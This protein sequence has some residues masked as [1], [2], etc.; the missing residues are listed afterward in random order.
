M[1][2]PQI[3]ASMALALLSLPADAKLKVDVDS[4]ATF[5]FSAAKTWAW[6]P[7]IPSENELYQGRIVAGVEAALAAEG[8]TRVDADPD[9]WVVTEV[10]TRQEGK[11][12]GG[13]VSIGLSRRTKYGS[14]GVG[15]SG[16]QRHTKVTVGTL[17]IAILG[18][19]EGLVWRA[20]ASDTISNNSEKTSATIQK[21]IDQ[22]FKKYPPPTKK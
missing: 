3:I 1:K 14:I 8:M 19:D 16:G 13:N 18:P 4:D 5:D 2:K 12:S 15:T 9:I 10:A 17:V 21:A 6:K 22:A 20:N 7:G 11:T